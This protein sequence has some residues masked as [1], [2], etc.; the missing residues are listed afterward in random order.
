MILPLSLELNG[1][2]SAEV[3]VRH[4]QGKDKDSS[5][6]ADSL[7]LPSDTEAIVPEPTEEPDDK[8]KKD[9]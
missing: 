9:K 5:G 4:D 1:Q 8:D 6:E 3:T 2:A 7:D